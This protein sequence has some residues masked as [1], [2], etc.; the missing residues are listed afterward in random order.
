[1]ADYYLYQAQAMRSIDAS[2]QSTDA[3]TPLM[4]QRPGFLIAHQC[5]QTPAMASIWIDALAVFPRTKA[6]LG[7]AFA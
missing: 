3:W 6:A 1:M 2:R 5:Y 7:A 4:H